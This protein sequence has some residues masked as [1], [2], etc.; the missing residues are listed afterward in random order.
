MTYLRN[1]SQTVLLLLL[2]AAPVFCLNP[3]ADQWVPLPAYSGGINIMNDRV[4]ITQGQLLSATNFIWKDGQI[5]AREGFYRYVAPLSAMPVT[6]M[7]VFKSP[8]GA[9]YLMYS[10]GINLWY[11][12]DI[13][14]E[15]VALS[16]GRA[17][18]GLVNTFGTV[19]RGEE[20]AGQK[21]RTIFGTGEGLTMT[22]G[23]TDYTVNKILLDT[24]AW[25]TAS[26]GT[27]TDQAHNLDY[28]SIRVQS[29]LVA[30]DNYWIYANTGK[31]YFNRPD[32]FVVVDSLSG[33]RFAFT[34]TTRRCIPST[35]AIQFAAASVVENYAGKFLRV[36][37]NPIADS[38]NAVTEGH[39]LYMSYP[40][41]SSGS[42]IIRTLGA[43]FLPDTVSDQ[44]LTVENLAYDSTTRFTTRVDSVR[45]GVVDSSAYSCV[46]NEAL[47]FKIYCDTCFFDS[48]TAA[49]ITGDWF[50][51]PQYTFQLGSNT[52]DGTVPLSY[53][54]IPTTALTVFP[55]VGGFRA[56]DGAFYAA[57]NAV[58]G[59]R[60][61]HDFDTNNVNVTFYRMKKDVSTLSAGGYEFAVQHNER[62]FECRSSEPDRLYWSEPFMPDSFLAGSIVIVDEANP[63]V[64]AAK[65][66]SD[67]VVYTTAGSWKIIAN[68][69]GE[70]YGTEKFNTSRGCVSRGSFLNI[71]NIHYGLAADGFWESDGNEPRI[72]SGPVSSYFLDSLNQNEYDEVRSGYDAE[73]DNIWVSLPRRGA[74]KNT[75]TLMYHRA[76]QSWWPQTFVGSSFT[77]VKDVTVSD[78]VR[79]MVGGVDSSTI[80]VRGGRLDDG[81]AIT[82]SIQTPYLDFGDP[83][84]A[85]RVKSLMLGYDSQV[86]SAVSV[87]G[88]RDF[89]LTPFDTVSFT[90]GASWA[91]KWL[92]FPDARYNGNNL[93]LKLS[94]S[95]ASQIKIPYLRLQVIPDGEEQ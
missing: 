63:C 30:S 92:H 4:Q 9:K 7:D 61:N 49:F 76:T 14:G 56:S 47:Y 59:S 40:I 35:P 74:T 34:A 88:Y 93:S 42:G 45:M 79:F 26:A 57:M 75:I 77:A 1:C 13:T 29:R 84:V 16:F 3:T 85:K 11:R 31:S 6:F 52:Y 95:N 39:H 2:F 33:V 32:S 53:T 8:L 43:A 54:Q 78:S 62:V 83:V 24:L 82:A 87:V 71:D 64:I 68:A 19:I 73:N 60:D 94:I 38:V 81:A 55:V 65:Q 66:W 17:D 5:Q 12:P 51:Y 70:E 44:Y 37:S 27:T 25:I 67:L 23:G 69:T 36:V 72:I 21:W 50:W 89:A 48:D 86:A 41:Y 58:G 80:Y 28:S 10:D 15:S 22:I 20:I 90:T 46:G 18:S 91:Q